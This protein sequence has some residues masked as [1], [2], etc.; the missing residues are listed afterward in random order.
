[1]TYSPEPRK[2]LLIPS[3]TFEAPDKKHLFIIMTKA[4]SDGF[5]LL[6]SVS[7]IKEGVKHD[8]TCELAAGSHPFIAVPSFILYAK[9][10]KVKSDLLV[11]CVK[12]WTY[13]PKETLDASVFSRVCLGVNASA[14]TPR[15]AKKYFAAN[16]A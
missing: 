3:G 4:C 8:P 6:V 9:S 5:H 16:S 1:M 2:T 12:S 7:S 10:D 11:K 15:W 14:H 13:T